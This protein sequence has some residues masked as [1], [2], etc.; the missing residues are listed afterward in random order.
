VKKSKTQNEMGK[1]YYDLQRNWTRKIAPHLKNETL[2]RIL[3]RDFNK[4]TMGRWRE[5]FLPGNFP[6]EFESCDWRDCHAHRGPRPRYW[7]YVKHSA[8]H[9]ITNF[10]L[11]LAQLAD[12]DRAWRIVTSQ[13]HSTVWDGQKTLFDFNLLAMGVH[14]DEAWKLAA[15]SKGSRVLP[16]GR[17]MKVYF[18]QH[19]SVT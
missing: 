2:N 17:E 10:A 18:A 8:C 19:F 14:V 15:E 1:Q 3:V 5:P 6:E 12:P 13:K 4:F 16:I 9:W 7:A 11:R